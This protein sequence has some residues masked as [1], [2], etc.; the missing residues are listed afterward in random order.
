M[1]NKLFSTL[2]AIV[3]IL[4]IML[5]G[6]R[7]YREIRPMTEWGCLKLNSQFAQSQCLLRISK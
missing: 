6:L 3:L 2:M 5:L 1:K 7:L 4:V